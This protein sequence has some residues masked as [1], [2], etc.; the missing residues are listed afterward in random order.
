MENKISFEIIAHAVIHNIHH[1]QEQRQGKAA[2]RMTRALNSKGIHVL[3]ESRGRL[4]REEDSFKKQTR[5][6]FCLL[7]N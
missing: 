3:T 7:C 4:S 5:R 6:Q 1:A 2:D